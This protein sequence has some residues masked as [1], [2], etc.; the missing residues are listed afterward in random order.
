[1]VNLQENRSCYASESQREVLLQLITDPTIEEHFFLTGGTALSVFYLHHRRSNDLDLFSFQKVNLPDLGF[2]MKG[3]WPQ[4]ITILSQGPHFLSSLV[5][6]TRVDL[7]IDPLSAN[8]KRST[9]CF[10]NGHKLQIDTIEAIASNK[11]CACVSRTEPKDYVDLYFILKRVPQITPER[12]HAL[13]K[14]KDAIFDD[15]PTAAYQV[16][17]GLALMK[18]HP[19]LIPPLL[20][21]FDYDDFIASFE[22]L[23]MGIYDQLKI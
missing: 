15:P 8:E 1:M 23:A 5:R 2:W 7:V 9:I 14:G 6:E 12:V 19:E 13:A 11:L 17:Q 18:E 22:E 4:K 16:E 20:T 21:D 10:E 3:M